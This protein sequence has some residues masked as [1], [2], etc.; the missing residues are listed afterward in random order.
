MPNH[1][2][3]STWEWRKRLAFCIATAS[4]GPLHSRWKKGQKLVPGFQRRAQ[5]ATGKN[6][7]EKK[8]LQELAV[9]FLYNF[10]LPF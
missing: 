2:R 8:L 9:R 10:K 4:G 5:M 3:H 7:R 1:A 6:E